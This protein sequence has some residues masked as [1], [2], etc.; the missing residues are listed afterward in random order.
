MEEGG[1]GRELYDHKADPGEHRNLAQDPAYAATVAELKALLP[2]GPVEKRPKAV[3][4]D[5]IRD[6]L[7]RPL[8]KAPEGDAKKPPAGG[9][10]KGGGEG[11]GAARVCSE[12]DP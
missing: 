6:C 2:K 12:I 3:S 1:L 10:A 5:P 7:V 8:T 11:G 9:E 4:Y